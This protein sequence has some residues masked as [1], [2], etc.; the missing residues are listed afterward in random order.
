LIDDDFTATGAMTQGKQIATWRSLRL[1]NYEGQ[2]GHGVEH[3]ILID[4]DFTATGAMT[5]KNT[6]RIGVLC[7]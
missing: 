1:T 4:D 2:S 5:H 6:L 3:R 7:G